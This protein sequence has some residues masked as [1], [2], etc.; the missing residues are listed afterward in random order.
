MKKGADERATRGP[1]GFDAGMGDFGR[2]VVLQHVVKVVEILYDFPLM[3]I[4]LQLPRAYSLIVLIQRT[5]V[6]WICMFNG[7]EPPDAL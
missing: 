4:I 6:V 3:I 1:E 2:L 5:P 7:S